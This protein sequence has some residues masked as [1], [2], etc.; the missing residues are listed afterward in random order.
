MMRLRGA[1]LI[2]AV[3]L[4]ASC[5]KSGKEWVVLP[6]KEALALME[7]CS[8]SFPRGLS[9]Y[10]D[11]G[12]ADV[13]RAELRFQEALRHALRRLPSEE[14]RAVPGVYHAQ[15]AGFFRDGHKVIYVNA[16]GE[17]Q[18]WRDHAILICDGGVI[19][20][21]AVLDLDRDSVDSFEF[22]GTMGGAIRMLP[23]SEDAPQP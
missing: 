8:R 1:I 15:Y 6:K 10:W 18:G 5:R 16:V 7:P 4:V 22:N 20:F 2:A 13:A 9:A 23:L 11:M 17:G 12:D 19:S 21:G 14:K 3:G